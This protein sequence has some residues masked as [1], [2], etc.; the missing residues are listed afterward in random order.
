MLS[1]VFRRTSILA[2]VMAKK[3]RS[4]EIALP[5]FRQLLSAKS[6]GTGYAVGCICS[7]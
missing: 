7:P 3:I 1:A 5:D 2:L 4:V 6:A